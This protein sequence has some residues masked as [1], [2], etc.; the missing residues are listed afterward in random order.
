MAGLLR[1]EAPSPS[2]KLGTKGRDIVGSSNLLLLFLLSFG[3]DLRSIDLDLRS[4]AVSMERSLI[5]ARSL[6]L[7]LNLLESTDPLRS[8]DTPRAEL[9]L[10]VLLFS[11]LG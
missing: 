7:D 8:L 9:E 10:L 4:L 1:S 2:G 11:S 3:L 6:D 5:G